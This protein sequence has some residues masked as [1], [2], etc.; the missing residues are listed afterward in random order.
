[1]SSIFCLLPLF[2]LLCSIFL[3]PRRPHFYIIVLFFFIVQHEQSPF[4]SAC[5]EHPS[6]HR[7]LRKLSVYCTRQA[8]LPSRAPPVFCLSL[9]L[10]C[11]A[12]LFYF[13]C[14]RCFSSCFWSPFFDLLFL[15]HLPQSTSSS[16][17]LGR[18]SRSLGLTD[19]HLA[20][21]TSLQP[22]FLSFSNIHLLHLFY[23]L[24]FYFVIHL[25][26]QVP[27]VPFHLIFF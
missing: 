10:S 16:F 1:M 11:A 23:Y 25:C 26:H 13:S 6:T 2:P 3:G 17:S 12:R 24:P 5:G 21:R 15:V 20:V 4:F 7:M 19:K 9:F 27:S 14:S 8:T 22:L 18:P